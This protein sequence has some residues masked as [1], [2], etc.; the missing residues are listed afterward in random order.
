MLVKNP[1]TAAALTTMLTV[2]VEHLPNG[3]GY[4]Y[5]SDQGKVLRRSRRLYQHVLTGVLSPA[6]TSPG[7]TVVMFTNNGD[8]LATLR[9]PEFNCWTEVRAFSVQFPS[10]YR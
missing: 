2:H 7:A 8:H 3:R 1:A 6:S 10:W 9:K 4:V 5:T